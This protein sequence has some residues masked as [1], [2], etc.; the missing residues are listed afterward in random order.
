[1]EL[2]HV[3]AR[4]DLTYPEF[5]SKVCHD[6]FGQMGSSISLPWVIY[7]EAFYLHGMKREKTNKIQQLDVYY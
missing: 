7:F 5:S 3:L 1:M 2:G 4:S 6:T